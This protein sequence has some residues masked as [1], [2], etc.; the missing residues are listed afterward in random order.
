MINAQNMDDVDAEMPEVP[1]RPVAEQR[2]VSRSSSSVPEQSQSV[3]SR[4]YTVPTCMEF[5]MNDGDDESSSS[6]DENT[7]VSV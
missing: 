1:A 7:N 5:F 4:K 3:P 2:D 6:E